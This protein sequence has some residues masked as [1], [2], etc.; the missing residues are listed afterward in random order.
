MTDK[1][2]R[3]GRDGTEGKGGGYTERYNTGAETGADTDAETGA[4][5]GAG[6]D[7]QV[8]RMVVRYSAAALQ[9]TG[10]RRAV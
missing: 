3:H 5:T 8:C 6:E 10:A 4:D 2:A 7:A 9:Y 1:E